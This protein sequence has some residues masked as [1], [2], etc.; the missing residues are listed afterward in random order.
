MRLFWLLT[1][2]LA[3]GLGPHLTGLRPAH[4]APAQSGPIFLN[5]GDTVQVSGVYKADGSLDTRVAK[6]WSVD[7]TSGS[8]TSYTVPLDP[9]LDQF[10][11]QVATVQGFSD[12]GGTRVTFGI[13]DTGASAVTFSAGDQDGF[14]FFGTPIPISAIVTALTRR[15]PTP[16]L[17]RVAAA[18]ILWTPCGLPEW[19]GQRKPTAAGVMHS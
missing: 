9:L 19:S 15:T 18:A 1:S 17:V 16:V 7:A 4:A 6:V 3:I 12:S 2:L 8:G 14:A 11:D 10:G 13:F 5:T